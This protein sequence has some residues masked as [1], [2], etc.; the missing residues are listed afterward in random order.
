MILPYYKKGR[1]YRI[2]CC[3]SSAAGHVATVQRWRASD[4]SDRAEQKD[5]GR[6]GS[7]RH[8]SPAGTEGGAPG[9]PRP[10]ILFSFGWSWAPCLWVTCFQ[11]VGGKMTESGRLC[12]FITKVKKGSLADTVGHL[13]PGKSRRLLITS[14]TQLS[15]W[16]IT[17]FI[18][19][20]S[21][22]ILNVT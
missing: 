3:D 1:I 22:F 6:D 17:S 13:R 16:T 8:R 9:P 2:C 21:G 12:A 18:V 4:W 5:E 10:C 14:I 11:V 15:Y 20:I 19:Y 7:C